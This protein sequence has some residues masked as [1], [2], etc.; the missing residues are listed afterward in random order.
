M[1]MLQISPTEPQTDTA[2]SIYHGGSQVFHS[3][4]SQ[5]VHRQWDPG[6]GK[7]TSVLDANIHLAMWATEKNEDGEHVFS[8]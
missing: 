1:A 2:L 4:S 3:A 5:A 6:W 7:E 8:F